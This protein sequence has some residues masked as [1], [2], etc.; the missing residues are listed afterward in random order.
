[1]VTACRRHPVP[2]EHRAR[3]ARAGSH[4]LNGRR[5]H[6]VDGDRHLPG[7]RAGTSAATSRAACSST[8]SVT[9]AHQAVAADQRQELVGRQHTEIGM[10]PPHQRLHADD[11]TGG[12]RDLR[13][14]GEPQ[15]ATFD[16]PAQLD[17]AAGS[18]RPRGSRIGRCPPRR[19]RCRTSPI[20]IPRANT[21]MPAHSGT[22]GHIHRHIGPLEQ[23]LGAR[24]GGSRGPGAAT[25]PMLGCM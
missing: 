2:G 3:S 11:L 19:A 25:T 20:C 4:P 5:E 17:R 21:W 9:G 6:R 12:Q 10:R 24:S 18:P 7:S 1:M 14:I 22:L 8:R 23:L 16:H 13:L 15:I